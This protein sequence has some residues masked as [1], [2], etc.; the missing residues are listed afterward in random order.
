[1]IYYYNSF[2]QTL[3]LNKFIDDTLL[4]HKLVAEFGDD[5]VI[6]D[7]KGKN[8]ACVLKCVPI[9]EIEPAPLPNKKCSPRKSK[10]RSKTQTHAPLPSTITQTLPPTTT[11]SLQ[12]TTET[13]TALPDIETLPIT[14]T[15][16]SDIIPTQTQTNLPFI[17]KSRSV[18]DLLNIPTERTEEAVSKGTKYL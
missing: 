1:M 15:T 17:T 4:E 7:I 6:K 13:T 9:E 16:Q 18:F 14:T 10:L 12:T 8:Y 3:Q 5:I 2:L 11:P